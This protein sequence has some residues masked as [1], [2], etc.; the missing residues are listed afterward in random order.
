MVFHPR[1]GA[2]CR[3]SQCETCRSHLYHI[4]SYGRYRIS[5]GANITSGSMSS[6]PTSFSSFC[7]ESLMMCCRAVAG[8][9]RSATASVLL[10]AGAAPIYATTRLVA[11]PA[12]LQCLMHALCHPACLT[13][14]ELLL[15]AERCRSS[16][17]ATDVGTTR[18][19]DASGR[20]AERV[21][22][23]SIPLGRVQQEQAHT[24][25]RRSLS[26]DERRAP[27][28]PRR[29]SCSCAP[30]C[31]SPPLTGCSARG[32]HNISRVGRRKHCGQRRHTVRA[33]RA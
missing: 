29:R 16:G 23:S 9:S 18:L 20:G 8:L 17:V 3:A 24:R 27:A 5:P 2:A 30:P 11:T 7:S 15:T 32:S 28:P 6:L 21:I 31:S 13:T 22:R 14:V 1:T 4:L 19:Q 26:R 33:V 12:G 25:R 10:N